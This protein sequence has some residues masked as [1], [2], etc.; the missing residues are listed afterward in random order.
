MDRGDDPPQEPREDTLSRAERW[1]WEGEERVARL[2]LR[3]EAYEE[4][5]HWAAAATAWSTL[6]TLETT[7]RL[8][9]DHLGM[10]RQRRGLDP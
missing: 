4:A 9:R 2:R 5:G 1:V 10:M 8:M 7:L 3:A 6:S